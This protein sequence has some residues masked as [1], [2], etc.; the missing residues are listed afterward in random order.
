MS[1]IVNIPRVEDASSWPQLMIQVPG[2]DV[3][4]VH[5]STHNNY[6]CFSID[7]GFVVTRQEISDLRQLPKGTT[8][9]ITNE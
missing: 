5:K 4:I 1:V 8:V 9:T 3:W 6:H 2:K 7:G